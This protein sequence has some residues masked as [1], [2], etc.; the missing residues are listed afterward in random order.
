MTRVHNIVNMLMLTIV[1]TSRSIQAST[2]DWALDMYLRNYSQRLAASK[3][4]LSQGKELSYKDIMDLFKPTCDKN[5]NYGQKQ[6]FMNTYCW[7]STPQGDLV[8]GTFQK[9]KEEEIECSKLQHLHA[10]SIF[11]RVCFCSIVKCTV[12]NHS[13]KRGE[14]FKIPE[15]CKAW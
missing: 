13:Y 7:C 11:N 4:L 14:Y 6:C 8:D 15:E 5:G 2:C 3:T 9:G 12:G 10:N 1:L